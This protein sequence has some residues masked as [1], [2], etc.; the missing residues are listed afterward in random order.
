MF[1]QNYDIKCVVKNYQ[2][3]SEN[4]VQSSSLNLSRALKIH[5]QIM[6]VLSIQSSGTNIQI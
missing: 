5:D 4:D 1:S 3:L 6:F 2:I